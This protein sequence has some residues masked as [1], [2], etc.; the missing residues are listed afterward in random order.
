[1]SEPN[2]DKWRMEGCQEYCR[3]ASYFN[4]E[5]NYEARLVVVSADG[6][7]GIIELNRPEKFNSLSLSVEERLPEVIRGFEAAESGVRV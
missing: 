3:T 2:A 1:M 6:L 4:V 7:V 5:E